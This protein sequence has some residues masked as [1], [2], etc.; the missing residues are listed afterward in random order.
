MGNK[1]AEIK[2]LLVFLISD[3]WKY[4][5]FYFGVLSNPDVQHDENDDVN[6]YIKNFMMI[7]EVVSLRLKSAK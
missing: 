6:N 4:L 1:S 5:I 3:K 2:R 7:F